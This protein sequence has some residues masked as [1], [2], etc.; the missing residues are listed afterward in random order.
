MKYLPRNDEL[1]AAR[2]QRTII[3][4]S[5]DHVLKAELLHIFCR[6]PA[7]TY[8][9]KTIIFETDAR[10]RN[11]LT[12]HHN[13]AHSTDIDNMSRRR[14]SA[15][16]QY[17][18]EM[19]CREILH[20]LIEKWWKCKIPFWRMKIN[21]SSVNQESEYLSCGGSSAPHAQY[22]WNQW[23]IVVVSCRYVSEKNCKCDMLTHLLYNLIFNMYAPINTTLFSLSR[24]SLTSS[25]H[26]SKRKLSSRNDLN[27][28]Y[29]YD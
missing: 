10:R 1:L 6:Q 13:V 4:T 12:T 24:K 21:I 2:P 5:T 8:S 29:N 16:A 22:L 25:I 14:Q 11:M 7:K 23:S 15:C 9:A 18:R 17:S 27:F 28:K 19:K 26:Q 3:I 20:F